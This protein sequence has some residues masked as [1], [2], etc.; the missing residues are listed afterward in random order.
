MGD[1]CLRKIFQKDI[2]N[3]LKLIFKKVAY[4]ASPIIRRAPGRR[5]FNQ[6]RGINRIPC[7][8]IFWERDIEK[9]SSKTREERLSQKMP[10]VSR[11]V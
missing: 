5:G 9:Q 7:Q 1:C 8:D 3:N 4:S 2:G 11:K 10:S 6:V